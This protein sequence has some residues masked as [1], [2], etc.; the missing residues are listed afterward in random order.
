MQAAEQIRDAMAQVA[1]LRVE[2]LQDPSLDSAV[3]QVKRLQARRFSGTYVDLLA[4]G[5]FRD[6]ALFFLKELYG[7]QDFADR[8]AQFARI[9]GAL[10]RL[11]PPQAV[12]TATA[13]ARLHALTE[14]LDHSMG[15]AW[16]R[17]QVGDQAEDA[18]RYLAAWRL[19]D[20]RSLRDAQLRE[21]LR[22]GHEMVALTR[23]SGLRMMLKMMRAPAAAAGL[24]SLQRFLERGFDTFSRLSRGKPGALE[25]LA[26]VQER[27][28]ALIATLFDADGPIARAELARTLGNCTELP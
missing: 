24:G 3:A 14:N 11:F 17:P 5:P 25:F 23:T 19:V 21:V 16:L 10:E 9:A 15:R 13:L 18:G 4:G 6:A 12:A 7:D 26:L 1:Q 22:I 28:A 20:D 8:D 27:E 2:A